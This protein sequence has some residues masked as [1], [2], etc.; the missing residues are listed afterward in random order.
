[1]VVL[2]GRPRSCPVA[3]EPVLTP[4]GGDDLRPLGG[5]DLR[6]AVAGPVGRLPGFRLGRQ[7]KRSR[8][9]LRAGMAWM[10]S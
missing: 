1:L 10:T 5:D 4:L 2:P 9:F 8:Y 7:G 6:W 3:P